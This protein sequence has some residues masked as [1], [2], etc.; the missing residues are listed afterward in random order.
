RRH[1]S[2]RLR[3]PAGAA[4]STTSADQPTPFRRLTAPAC[5]PSGDVYGMD[6][7]AAVSS[8]PGRPLGGCSELSWAGYVV[9]RC[10]APGTGCSLRNAAIPAVVSLDCWHL[11]PVCDWSPSPVRAGGGPGG[12]RKRAVYAG[13]G[14]L[15]LPVRPADTVSC[16]GVCKSRV[17]G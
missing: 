9:A 13:C 6:K 1:P 15:A 14:P 3:P 17:T 5:C 8:H 16:H 11:G 2:V 7:R 10:A 12:Q 4:P